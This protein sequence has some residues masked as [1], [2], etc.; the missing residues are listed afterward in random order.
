M[1]LRERFAEKE[2]QATERILAATNKSGY[3]IGYGATT[4]KLEVQGLASKIKDA[5]TGTAAAKEFSD[6]LFAGTA[7]ATAAYAQRCAERN[8][9]ARERADARAAEAAA[10]EMV[11]NI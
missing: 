10:Q 9:K 7:D 11:D 2:Q 6:G 5:V 3:G 1:T 4:V 8:Q